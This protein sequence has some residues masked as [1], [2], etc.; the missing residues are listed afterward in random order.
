VDP[1]ALPTVVYLHTQHNKHG[2]MIGKFDKESILEHEEKFKSGKL[3]IQDIK[4]D[5]R[6]FIISDVDCQKEVL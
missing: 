2:S 5:P 4:V 3:P 1:T 6:E